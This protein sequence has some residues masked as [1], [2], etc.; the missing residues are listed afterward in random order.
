LPDF[1][2]RLPKYPLRRRAEILIQA[3][4]IAWIVFG[5]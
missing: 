4:Q 1:H 2:V 3:K 5:L